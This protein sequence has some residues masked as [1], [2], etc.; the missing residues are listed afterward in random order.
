MH[1]RK[2]TVYIIIL[3]LIVII[4]AILRFSLLPHTWWTGDAARDLMVS[5]HIAHY[6]EY[7]NIGHV[8]AW[9]TPYSFYPPFYYYLLSF[10]QFWITNP[11]TLLGIFIITNVLTIILV[12]GIAKTLK[13]EWTG[14]IAA[15]LY[16]SSPYYLIRQISLTS[17]YTAFIIF[18]VGVYLHVYGI[19][20]K[21]I[22]PMCLSFLFLTTAGSIN[23]AAMILL[24]VF[25]CWSLVVFK[26]SFDKLFIMLDVIAVTLYI[27][28]TPMVLFI[29][30]F[31][32][33]ASFIKPFNPLT[34][35]R[36]NGPISSH[37]VTNVYPLFKELFP[38]YTAVILVIVLVILTH[39]F[40]KRAK[41]Y[42]SALLYPLSLFLFTLLLS[43]IKNTVVPTYLFYCV[44]AMFLIGLAIA[45][46]YTREL[47]FPDLFRFIVPVTIT[48]I[49]LLSEVHQIPIL[50]REPLALNDAQHISESITGEVRSIRQRD[51]YQDYSFFH[52]VALGKENGD[53]E[54]TRYWYFLE[55]NLG[56]LTSVD[57]HYN[58]LRWTAT[59]PSYE[60]LVCEGSELDWCRK[61]FNE[62][63][64]GYTFLETIHVSTP[65][66]LILLYKILPV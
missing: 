63:H 3:V 11:V 19:K 6:H 4:S 62:L 64:P 14:V 48:V 37:I 60:F 29:T 39:A 61:K 56:K 7:P 41:Q 30:R 50:F 5:Y 15:L 26:K 33:F 28:Y 38:I 59:N 66:Q 54:S 8:S 55:R 45:I 17:M 35:T 27:L 49:F 10:F 58:N 57:D 22:L 32:G 52:V 25:F 36:M 34:N 51:E 18:L 1:R 31:Y 21:R 42:G 46:R 2:N 53:W 40:L 44:S 43:L 47:P 23:Y 9:T 65:D 20:H 13:D 16:A 12:Y 24:P